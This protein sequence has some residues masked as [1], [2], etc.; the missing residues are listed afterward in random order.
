MVSPDKAI[1]LGVCAL[2]AVLLLFLQHRRA[3]ARDGRSKELKAQE[4]LRAGESEQ[5]GGIADELQCVRETL[6]TFCAEQA[7][8]TGR[9][10]RVEARVG[11]LDGKVDAALHRARYGSVDISIDDIPAWLATLGGAVEQFRHMLADH[12]VGDVDGRTLLHACS[13]N[14]SVDIARLLLE[15]GAHPDR[16]GRLGIGPTPLHICSSTGSAGVAKLLIDSRAAPDG[17]LDIDWLQDVVVAGATPLHTCSGFDTAG[18]AKLL[19]DAGVD[20]E[21]T[22]DLGATPLIVCSKT[23]S[24][25]VAQLLIEA[26]ANLEAKDDD[27]RTPLAIGRGLDH[28]EMVELLLGA[29]ADQSSE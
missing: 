13:L 7:F 9:L 3:A 4:Q 17:P 20:K 25:N 23:R 24:V 19:L 27:G 26:G 28:A 22:D 5:L 14:D 11:A 21:A 12:D 29:G 16:H 8:M 15:A 6:R 10:L 1:A 18:V 2:P